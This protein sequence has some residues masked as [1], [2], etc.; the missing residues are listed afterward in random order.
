MKQLTKE[1]DLDNKV[2]CFQTNNTQ[3]F[4]AKHD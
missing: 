2:V 1:R 3:V 4:K